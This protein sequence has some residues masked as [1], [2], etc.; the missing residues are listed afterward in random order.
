MATGRSY[1]KSYTEPPLTTLGLTTNMYTFYSK[2]APGPAYTLPM[3]NGKM[4]IINDPSLISAAFRARTL[5]FDPLLLTTI[6]YMIPISEE[7]SN[8]FKSDEFFHPWSKVIYSKMNGTELLKMNVVVLSDI[9]DKINH[10][11]QN[12]EV[13]N[14]FVWFRSLLTL[15]TITSLLGRD[16]PWNKDRSL[17]VTF[18]SVYLSLSLMI[19]CKFCI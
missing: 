11:P 3:L 14:T 19:W 15:S 16:N 17:V 2:S 13:E 8:V 5:S 10:L 7:A 4:Y 12:M 6:K 18:W 1:S 9:F